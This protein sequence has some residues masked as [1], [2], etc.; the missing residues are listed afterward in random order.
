MVFTQLTCKPLTVPSLI[1][2]SAPEINPG[3]EHRNIWATITN[4]L[5]AL[6]RDLARFQKCLSKTAISKFLPVRF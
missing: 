1:L 2:F 3:P 5:C 4:L 6:C